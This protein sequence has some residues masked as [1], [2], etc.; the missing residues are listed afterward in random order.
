MVL[1]PLNFEDRKERKTAGLFT[2]SMKVDSV[3]E[4]P[5]AFLPI[6]PRLS[7]KPIRH[8]YRVYSRSDFCGTRNFVADAPEG[9]CAC[10]R[11]RGARE[12][13]LPGP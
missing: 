4:T 3:V 9:S 8:S 10:T 7:R 5:N 1:D 11:F 2:F 12:T 6:Q 13:R